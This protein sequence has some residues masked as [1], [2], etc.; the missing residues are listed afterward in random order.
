MILDLF[1]DIFIDGYPNEL[2]QCFINILITQKMLMKRQI[3]KSTIFYKTQKQ[4]NQV[5]IK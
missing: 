1:D 4:N 2:I 5:I 3:K